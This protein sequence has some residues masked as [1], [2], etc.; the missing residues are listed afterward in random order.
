MKNTYLGE[1]TEKCIT[2]LVPIQKEVSRIDKNG[3]EIKKT[4]SYRLQFI[5]STRFMAS[6][7]SSVVNNLAEEFI[8]I[9]ANTNAMIKNVKLAE[10]NAN[11]A[12]DFLNT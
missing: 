1:N 8:K 2:F 6:P 9:N 12:T 4:L 3:E 7:L 5:D 11:I 10:L